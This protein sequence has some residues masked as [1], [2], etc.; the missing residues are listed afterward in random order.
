MNMIKEKNRGSVFVLAIIISAVLFSIGISITSILQKEV[1][2]QAYVDQSISAFNI[3]NTALECTLYNDFRRFVFSP[4]SVDG[5]RPRSINCG[6][7]Y[8]VRPINDWSREYVVSPKSGTNNQPGTGEYEYVVIQLDKTSV[9]NNSVNLRSLSEVPCASIT[10]KKQCSGVV[11]NGVCK[12][13][14]IENFIEVKGYHSCSQGNESSR[15]VVR[16]FRIKY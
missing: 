11:E 14:L 1:A 8:K 13:G 6:I 10:L 9:S 7:L 2:R 3:G 4:S 16:R 15:T 5:T 12:D